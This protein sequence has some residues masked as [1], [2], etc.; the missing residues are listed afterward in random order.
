MTPVLNE[1][2][3]VYASL[4]DLSKIDRQGTICEFKEK[5]GTTV[6]IER[7][8]L[9]SSS[10]TMNLWLPGSLW[11]STLPWRLLA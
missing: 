5:E 2:E 1:G 11:K 8:R 9:T 7:K 3:Y 6:V 4:T 10:Y